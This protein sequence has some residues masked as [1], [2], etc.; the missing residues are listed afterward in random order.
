MVKHVY[1]F[2]IIYIS[3]GGNKIMAKR[4]LYVIDENVILNIKL[5]A[6]KSGKTESKYIND[7][8]IDHILECDENKEDVD[9][10]IK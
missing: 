7:L 4:K 10:F 9:Y 1:F 5:L 6:L 8:L 2:D 3:K